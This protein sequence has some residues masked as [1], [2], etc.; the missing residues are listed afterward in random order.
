M[1]LL[2]IT[3]FTLSLMDTYP[4]KKSLNFKK[5]LNGSMLS[6]IF[7]SGI[8]HSKALLKVL[9]E[10]HMGGHLSKLGVKNTFKIPCH[11]YGKRGGDSVNT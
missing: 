2:V 7:C 1:V 3:D 11:V 4:P 10:G 9:F 6:R 8:S 5:V